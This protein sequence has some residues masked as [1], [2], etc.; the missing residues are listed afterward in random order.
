MCTDL[1][2]RVGMNFNFKLMVKKDK[3]VDKFWGKKAKEKWTRSFR[4]F[5]FV[6]ENIESSNRSQLQDI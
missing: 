3:I 4:W 6:V 5:N 1:M 2:A